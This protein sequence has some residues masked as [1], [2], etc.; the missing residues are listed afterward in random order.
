M[1]RCFKLIGYPPN[2]GKRNNSSNTNQNNQNFNRRFISNN[3]STGSSS[4]FSDEQISKLLSLR[5]E[6]SLGDKGKGVQANMA[7]LMDVKIMEIG[8]Q[9]NG[10]Y[11][12]DN[13]EAKQTRELFPLSEHKSFV[14]GEL[15]HLDLWGPYMVVS[16]EGHRYFLTIVDDFTRA[17]WVY[18]LKSKEENGIVERKHR[19]PSFVL[20]G[21][22]PYELLFMRVLTHPMINA[23][24]HSDGSHSSQPSSPIIDHYES[25]LGHSQG[26]NGS[27]SESE[28]AATSAHNTALSEDD[29]AV[30][31]AMEHV[32]VLNNQPLKRSERASVFP[33]K[34]ND[35]VVDS[36]VKYG[37]E[38][39][40]G[41]DTWE[42][43]DLPKDRK[44]IGGKWVFK[45]K[46]KLNG[47][48]ERYKARYV[49]KEYNQKE[50]IDFDETF[51]PVVKIVT[52]RG[53]INMVVQ[54]NW[55]LFQLD[56]NN[57]FLYGEL[58]ETVYMDLPEVYYSPD[59]KRVCKLKK[60]LYGLKYAPRKWNAKLTQTL[61]ECGFKQS[62]SDY[63]L[64]TK[65]EK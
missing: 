65:F 41:N 50:G 5:K 8:R 20:K 23:H 62:K 58:D 51:S 29:I 47:K 2:F 12:F 52:V 59:D 18:L 45:I 46:Y 27:A 44:S 63:S 28:R 37:I 3:N 26:F 14:L 38:K 17:V 60:S 55:S 30:D 4:T 25:D 10:L 22:S 35:Y 54:N 64:F 40:V 36:K 15:V 57:A 49:V 11:Y 13:M 61:V 1:D 24:D 19:L 56:I 21:K 6:N 39:Y 16:K 48:I 9:V 42:I 31:D 53:L 7:D 43:C 32:H 34:Y 33:N